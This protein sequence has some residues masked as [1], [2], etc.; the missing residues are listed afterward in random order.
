M[1]N[2]KSLKNVELFTKNPRNFNR[3]KLTAVVLNYSPYSIVK[4]TKEFDGFA[5]ERGSN[6]TKGMNIFGIE[7]LL[8]TE[9]VK[10]HNFSLEIQICKNWGTVYPNGT[11]IHVYKYLRGNE[12]D[13]AVSGLFTPHPNY[14]FCSYSCPIQK[15]R[16]AG[17]VPRPR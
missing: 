1:T 7:G 16:I 6:I 4:R 9:F 14:L 8:L 11:G 5:T 3:K 12:A 10:R 15:T 2:S 17:M 13:L